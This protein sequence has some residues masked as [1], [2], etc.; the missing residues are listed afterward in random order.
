L[1]YATGLLQCHVM[2]T[3]TRPTTFGATFQANV[4]ELM[5]GDVAKGASKYLMVTG[6]AD[7]PGAAQRTGSTVVYVL[8]T[9]TGAFV[10]YGVPFDRTAVNSGRPQAGALVPLA[11]GMARGVVDRDLGR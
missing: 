7:F 5:A 3:R 8:D 2:Y 9:V 4:K 1:D 6:R 10:A 11:N